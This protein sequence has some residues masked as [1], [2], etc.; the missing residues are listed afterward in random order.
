MSEAQGTFHFDLVWSACMALLVAGLAD[1]DVAPVSENDFSGD[2]LVL[3]PPSVRT[4]FGGASFNPMMDSQR[5]SYDAAGRFVAICADQD[6]TSPAD[7]AIAS[8]QLASRVCDLLTGARIAL[9]TREAS[10]PVLIVS[11]EPRPVKGLGT[12]YAIGF[13]VPGL[14]LFP[15]P[16]AYPEAIY[17]GQ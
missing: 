16:N 14:A 2:D 15:G 11:M 1:C 17:G 12:A 9:P 8:L 13:E 10:E 6:R 4:F 3:T 5:L 7:Q